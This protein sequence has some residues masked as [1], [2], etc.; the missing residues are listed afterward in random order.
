MRVPK[1][2][3]Q[4]FSIFRIFSSR[5]KNKK[6]ELGPDA[7]ERLRAAKRQGGVT[8]EERCKKLSIGSV[9]DRQ[10]DAFIS[11]YYWEGA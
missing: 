1:S 3:P 6:G 10:K 11:I 5:L 4:Q 7:T 2:R 8:G 9:A